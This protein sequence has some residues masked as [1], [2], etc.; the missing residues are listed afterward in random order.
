MVI[1]LPPLLR[2]CESPG[3]MSWRNGRPVAQATLPTRPLY[4]PPAGRGSAHVSPYAT[5]P[6]LRHH[7]CGHQTLRE[8][9]RSRVIWSLSMTTVQRIIATSCTDAGSGARDGY[10]NS[11]RKYESRSTGNGKSVDG[12]RNREEERG[13]V[14]GSCAGARRTSPSE[15]EKRCGAGTGWCAQRP[16]TTTFAQTCGRAG[17]RAL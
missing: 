10:R 13:F 8:G 9:R 11:S 14:G 15:S 5:S 2:A 16:E 3:L 6:R 7:P 4:L 12:Q 1:L 17:A